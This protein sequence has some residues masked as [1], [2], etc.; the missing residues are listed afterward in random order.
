MATQAGPNH[1]NYFNPKWS[2]RVVLPT[3]SS[4]HWQTAPLECQASCPDVALR[5][6]LLGDWSRRPDSTLAPESFASPSV[7]LASSVAGVGCW[8]RHWPAAR[9][10]HAHHVNWKRIETHTLLAIFFLGH[11]L[12]TTT[13]PKDVTLAVARARRYSGVRYFP[14]R[15]LAISAICPN[16]AQAC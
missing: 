9:P 14:L 5:G 2:T 6:L 13:A 7:I 16:N 11:Y 12:P 3:T 15:K 10:L 4:H 1:L 8:T